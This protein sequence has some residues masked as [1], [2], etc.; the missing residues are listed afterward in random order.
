MF[1]LIVS[2]DFSSYVQLILFRTIL[3]YHIINSFIP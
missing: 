1:Y 3:H 2:Y